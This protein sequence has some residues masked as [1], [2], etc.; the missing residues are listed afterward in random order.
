MCKMRKSHLEKREEIIIDR[1]TNYLGQKKE[2]ADNS[3][4]LSER[5][6]CKR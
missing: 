5:T 4:D 6:S 2:I 1:R 3:F